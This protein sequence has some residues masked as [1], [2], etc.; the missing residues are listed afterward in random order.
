MTLV[1]KHKKLPMVTF[2]TACSHAKKV[3]TPK[4]TSDDQTVRVRSEVTER[5]IVCSISK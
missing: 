1:V 2:G 3:E 5:T 4:Q